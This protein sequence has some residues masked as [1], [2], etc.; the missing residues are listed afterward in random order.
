[1]TI[2]R[3]LCSSSRV[4][5]EQTGDRSV[6]LRQSVTFAKCARTALAA[7]AVNCLD[8]SIYIFKY[9]KLPYS[10]FDHDAQKQQVLQL[11]FRSFQEAYK[12]LAS[13]DQRT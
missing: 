1:M 9:C 2:S 10:T 6:C 5:N 8:E 3:S 7:G 13:C 4:L 11:R 12:W